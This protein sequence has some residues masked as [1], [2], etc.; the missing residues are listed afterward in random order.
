MFSTC[1][2]HWHSCASLQPD[3]ALGRSDG[4]FVCR[5]APQPRLAL[6]AAFGGLAW[7]C[8]QIC[9][10]I[11]GRSPAIPGRSAMAWGMTRPFGLVFPA[12]AIG[13]SYFVL[14]IQCHTTQGRRAGAG[15]P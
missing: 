10:F 2:P 8:L 13:C 14:G 15:L 11:C 6:K 5:H 9:A 4:G 3:Q 12:A 7:V 1:A